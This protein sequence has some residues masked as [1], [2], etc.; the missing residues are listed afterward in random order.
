MVLRTAATNLHF[1][2]SANCLGLRC[3]LTCILCIRWQSDCGLFVS[4]CRPSLLF[5]VFVIVF[6]NVGFPVCATFDVTS[7]WRS[8]HNSCRRFVY[9]LDDS[10][11]PIVVMVF[12]MGNDW[13]LGLLQQ[14]CTF[15]VLPIVHV[16]VVDLLVYFAIDGKVMRSYF[17]RLQAF[18]FVLCV[19]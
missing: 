13:C 1:Y 10:Y 16:C 11:L 4:G 8:N 5:F 17:I 15:T 19:C 6:V 2:V 14:T 12:V 7:L 3:R 18:P 9:L